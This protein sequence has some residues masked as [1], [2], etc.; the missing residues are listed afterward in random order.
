MLK[1]K[2]QLTV[3]H[4][5]EGTRRRPKHVQE[6]KCLPLPL[7]SQKDGRLASRRHD[8][9]NVL[10]VVKRVPDHLGGHLHLYL[11]HV[12]A[13][14]NNLVSMQVLTL[15]LRPHRVGRRSALI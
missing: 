3:L 7:V 9:R 15:H 11:M 6:T 2:R 12:N 1:L 10:V 8:N 4:L 14:V 5:Q 13:G